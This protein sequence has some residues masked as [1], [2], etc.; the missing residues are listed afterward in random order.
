MKKEQWNSI[1]LRGPAMN[2]VNVETREALKG[3]R[4]G[5]LGKVVEASFFGAPGVGRE[6]VGKQFRNEVE[7]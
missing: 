6:P 2:E 3:D 7:A 5:E 4:C 1:G